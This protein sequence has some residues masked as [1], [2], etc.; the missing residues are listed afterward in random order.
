MPWTL[1]ALSPGQWVS[2]YLPGPRRRTAQSLTAPSSASSRAGQGGARRRPACKPLRATPA[3]ALTHLHPTAAPPLSSGSP[4]RGGSC[5]LMIGCIAKAAGEPGA[6]LPALTVDEE[7][8]EEVRWVSR[9]GAQKGRKVCSRLGR[10]AIRDPIGSC[11]LVQQPPRLSAAPGSP[12]ASSVS[13]LPMP[14]CC[15]V[16]SPLPLLRTPTATPPHHRCGRGGAAERGPRLA[17]PRRQRRRRGPAAGLLRAPS[18]CD[19]APPAQALGA[20]RRALVCGRAALGGGGPCC[21]VA[22]VSETCSD[23]GPPQRLCLLATCN[24]H[25]QEAFCGQ[26]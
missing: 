23:A 8:M 17:V 20:A 7:E 2:I 6:G 19:R 16:H 4:G 10:K 1:W 12:A 9:A 24:R 26:T 25:A 15:S 5:E 14:P 3:F 18:L 21:R 22:P 13:F 11:M